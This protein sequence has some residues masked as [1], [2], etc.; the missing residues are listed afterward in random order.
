MGFFSLLAVKRTAI[1]PKLV[2]THSLKGTRVFFGFH[3][4]VLFLTF[5]RSLLIHCRLEIY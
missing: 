5:K 1:R 4:D 2:H 3:L